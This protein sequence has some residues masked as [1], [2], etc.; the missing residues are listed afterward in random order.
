MAQSPNFQLV[1]GFPA[2][3]L[4]MSLLQDV[5]S[6]NS[7]L[8]G[9]LLSS[10]VRE[11][12]CFSYLPEHIHHQYP[13]PPLLPH[14]RWWTEEASVRVLDLGVYFDLCPVGH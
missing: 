8:D 4:H 6:S 14:A 5:L 13:H 9:L 1:P 12:L 2:S 11:S 10:I 3:L 7:F